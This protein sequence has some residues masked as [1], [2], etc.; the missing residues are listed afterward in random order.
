MKEITVQFSV[1]FNSLTGKFKTPQISS[2]YLGE[3]YQLSETHL[4][5]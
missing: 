1:N 2:L 4:I 3:L 5:I